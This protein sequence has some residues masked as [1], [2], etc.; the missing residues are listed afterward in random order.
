[1]P[2]T[3]FDY[4]RRG[5]IYTCYDMVRDCRADR[6]EGWSYFISYY[7]PVLRKLLAHYAPGQDL[8]HSVLL[9]VR[10]PESSMFASLEPAPER[11][12]LAEL[13]QQ[14]LGALGDAPSPESAL[15]LETL[16]A[17]LQP[18]TLVEK[19]AVWLETMRYTSEDAGRV[20]RMDPRTIEKIREKAAAS[21]RSNLD[22][23]SRDMLASNGRRLGQAAA[24]ARSGDCLPA[25]AFL[26]VLD[27]RTTWRGREELERHVSTCWHCIDHFCR[28]AE[29]VEWV[30]GLQP[31]AESEAEPLRK[32]LGVEP[33]KRRLWNK[34]FGG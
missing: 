32:L 25:K 30:R 13:R 19:Q 22:T 21:L 17:A 18:L 23:W 2:P 4:H 29:V 33:R 20:L 28:M 24:A 26:D 3:G 27:G 5:M 6:P 31:L 34:M 8:L 11:W 12:F 1:M 14:A 15:D 7:V 9:A 16:T 10:Q